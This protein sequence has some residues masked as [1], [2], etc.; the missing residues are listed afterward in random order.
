MFDKAHTV[1]LTEEGIIPSRAGIKI[2]KALRQ[3]EK[4]GVQEIRESLGGHMHCGEAY[5]ARIAGPMV[6]GWIHCGRSSGDLE[7]VGSRVEAR[8]VIIAIMKGLIDLRKTFL[9]EAEEHV[10]TVMPG[11]THLQHAEPWSEPLKLDTLG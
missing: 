7:A 3:M 11:Y 1:M 4:E 8:D 6:A 2:L 10:D 9:K 5:V